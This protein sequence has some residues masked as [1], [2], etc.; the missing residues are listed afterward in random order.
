MQ[1]IHRHEPRR[2]HVTK[3]YI[4]RRS[5]DLNSWRH[6]VK[7][8]FHHEGVVGK[9]IFWTYQ[10]GNSRPYWSQSKLVGLSCFFYIAPSCGYLASSSRYQDEI[11]AYTIALTLSVYFVLVSCVSFLADYVYIPVLSPSEA[12]RFIREPHLRPPVTPS[13]WGRR[14]RVVAGIGGVAAIGDT[15]FRAGL[16]ICLLTAITSILAILWS[17]HANS[18]TSWIIRHS[19]WHAVSSFM[20]TMAALY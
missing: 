1:V 3:S 10:C 2:V 7:R 20:L 12:S 8:A 18:K 17:R 19:L 6:T 14:D 11:L 5:T 16:G 4:D 15:L 9:R 13:V